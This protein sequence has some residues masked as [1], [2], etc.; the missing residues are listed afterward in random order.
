MKKSID[1]I[2]L[3][4]VSIMDGQELGAVKSFV[5]NAAEGSVGC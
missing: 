5:I 1:I 2:G 3:P 4:V